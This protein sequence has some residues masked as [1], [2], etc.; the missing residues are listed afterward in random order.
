LKKT[1]HNSNY[2][3]KQTTLNGEIVQEYTYH[4]LGFV[5]ANVVRLKK[6]VWF[7]RL[8]NEKIKS[9]ENFCD[10]DMVRDKF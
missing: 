10:S 9:V 8:N 2:K 1:K 4:V 5:P 7:S 3:I 6:D